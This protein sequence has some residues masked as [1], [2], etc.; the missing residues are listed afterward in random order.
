MSTSAQALNQVRSSGRAAVQQRVI[1]K[2]IAATGW[3]TRARLAEITGYPINVV[4]PR[5]CELKARSLI[6]RVGRTNEKYS[7]QVLSITDK[8][9]EWLGGGK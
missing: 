6:E 8:G 2:A 1:L 5:V 7:K 9:R 3:V 4:T